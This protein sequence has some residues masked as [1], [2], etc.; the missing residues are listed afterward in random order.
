MAGLAS[1]V[2]RAVRGTQTRF[3]AVLNDTRR[4]TIEAI[5]AE[6]DPGAP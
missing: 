2:Q 4:R 6:V 1:H 3:E 5:A